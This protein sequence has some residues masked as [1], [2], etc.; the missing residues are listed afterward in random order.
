[1]TDAFRMAAEVRTWLHALCASDPAT[2]R[3]AGQAV[4]ALLDHE[5]GLGPPLLAALPA[6]GDPD[7][8][9]AL[10]QAYQRNLDM[11]NGVRRGIADIATARQRVELQMNQPWSTSAQDEL[12]RLRANYAELAHAEEKLTADSQRLQAWLEDFRARKE[13]LKAGYTAAEAQRTVNEAYAAFAGAGTPPEVPYPDADEAVARAHSAAYAFT[14]IADELGQ[15]LRGPRSGAGPQD[16]VRPG[17][18]AMPGQEAHRPRLLILRPCAPGCLRVRLVF[19]AEPGGDAGPAQVVLLTATASHGGP[20][21]APEELVA[22]LARY[23]QARGDAADE[24]AG[25]GHIAYDR[26]SFLGEFFPGQEDELTQGA[27]ALVA[28]NQP[29]ELAEL[30]LRAGLTQVQVAQRLGVRQERVSALERGDPGAVEV[31]TLAA[32]VEALGGRLE[33]SADLGADRVLLR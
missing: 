3:L 11:L 17:T 18:A 6:G 30:R 10:D 9:M 22:A 8:R 14:E 28:G 7:P 1:M 27:A 15:S 29:L 19:A 2:A 26:P 31:R 5:T 12:A 32:Y 4:V 25:S 21:A 24:D 16:E 33:I 13:T 20:L 23:R